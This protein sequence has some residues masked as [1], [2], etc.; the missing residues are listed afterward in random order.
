MNNGPIGIFDSGV[1]GLTVLKEI[2]S[3]YPN[4]NFLYL[5]DIKRFPYG[6]KS[7]E[8]IIEFTKNGIDFL[9]SKGAVAIVIACGTATSQALETVKKCYD[10]PIVGIIDKTIEYIKEKGYKKIGIIATSGTINSNSWQNKIYENIPDAIIKQNACPVL[11]PL[12]EKGLADSEIARFAIKQYLKNFKDVECLI[13][14]CT[15]YPLFTNIIREELGEDKDIINTGKILSERMSTFIN[16]NSQEQEN[17]K[18]QYQIYITDTQDSFANVAYQILHD[19]EVA[20]KIQ[21]IDE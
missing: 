3:K 8:A 21:V 12:A 14:G 16:D 11:A 7:K 19:D 13:L 18:G 10:L 1:G 15:H 4:S 17:N 5:G 2:M 20:K 9:I 6:D